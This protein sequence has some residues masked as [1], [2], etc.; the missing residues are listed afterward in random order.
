MSAFTQTTD[1]G[2]QTLAVAPTETTL[3]DVDSRWARRALVQVENLDA[4]QTL[5]CR[6]RRRLDVGNGWTYQPNLDLDA[7]PPLGSADVHLDLAAGLSSYSITGSFSGAGSNARV[8]V[9]RV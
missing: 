2:P 9:R 4:A 3:V 7:I 5:S 6:V 8:T 1:A